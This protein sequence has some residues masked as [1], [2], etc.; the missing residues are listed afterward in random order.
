MLSSHLIRGLPTGLLSQSFAS[1]SR[2]VILCALRT[3]CEKAVSS[4]TAVYQLNTRSEAA[5]TLAVGFPSFCL[6][7]PCSL[8]RVTDVSEKRTAFTVKVGPSSTEVRGATSYNLRNLQAFLLPYKVQMDKYSGG[9]KYFKQN[10][11]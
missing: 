8:V 1:S 9:K 5:T 2:A 11:R 4:V 6:V 10:S 3:R 7:T